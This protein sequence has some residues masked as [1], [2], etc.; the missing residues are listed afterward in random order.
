MKISDLILQLKKLEKEQ[1]IKLKLKERT[2]TRTF[3]FLIN[4]TK[5]FSDTEQLAV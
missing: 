1:Q 2:I 4:E 5:Q 3:C